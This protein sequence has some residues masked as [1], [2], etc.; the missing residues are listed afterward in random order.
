MRFARRVSGGTRIQRVGAAF[1]SASRYTAAPVT[2][3]ARGIRRCRPEVEN[4]VYFTC[5]AAIDNA[6]KHAGPAQI[7]VHAWDT[8]NALHFTVCDTGRGLTMSRPRPGPD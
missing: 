7:S 2:V 4:A 1:V 8:A 6:D 3:S 5:L